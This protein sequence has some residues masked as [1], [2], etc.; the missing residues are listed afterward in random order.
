MKKIYTSSLVILMLTFFFLSTSGQNLIPL[1]NNRFDLGI[2]SSQWRTLYVNNIGASGNVNIGG[3]LGVTGMTNLNGLQVKGPATFTGIGSGFL[4]TNATG[5]L[6]A[7]PLTS[8]QIPTLPYLPLTGGALSGNLSGTGASFNNLS[9][10]SLQITG[11]TGSMITPG[12]ILTTDAYGNATWAPFPISTFSSGFWSTTGN[13]QTIDGVNFI[14][15]TDDVPLTIKVNGLL[16]GRIE[17]AYPGGNTFFG[18]GAGSL[19]TT[20]TNNTAFGVFALANH[21]TGGGNTAIGD[22]VLIRNTSGDYNTILG[23]AAFFTNETGSFLTGLG[24]G[25]DVNQ[26]GYT[27]ST[28]IGGSAIIDASNEIMLGNSEITTIKAAVTGITALS[29]GRFKKNI[30][31]NVPGLEFIKLLK[32]VTY[33]YN[34]K[35]LKTYGAPDKSNVQGSKL[36]I[37][38][39]PSKSED[40][41]IALKEKIFYTGLVAQDVETAAKKAGY[42]F[43][44]LYKPQNGKDTYGLNYTEFVV[45]L[46]KAT[47]QLANLNDSLQTQI[48]SLQNQL[49][50]IRAQLNSLSSS[51]NINKESIS[52]NSVILSSA[53]M[54]QNVPN[55]FNQSTII[56]YYIPH[57]SGNATVMVSD[58]NGRNI[59]TVPISAMGN[60]Q[61]SLQ[62]S[63]LVS[64]TY[65]YSLY[66]DGNLVDSKKMVLAK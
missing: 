10:Q 3:A 26:D 58:I 11:A 49:N 39:Q 45:P 14:G 29:D 6:T 13:A 43:S 52:A 66:I 59:K 19:N 5:A 25:T 40:A 21:N 44:G 4:S 53:H 47:Q 61:I 2:P 60:G 37:A 33:N 63:Q 41:A 20:G 65:I 18:Y 15:T 31:E 30:K 24:A 12:N 32:P 35:G 48:N 36:I 56:N 22:G 64:G 8:A 54:D 50:E 57:S 51:G 17:T 27:N 55:P 7:A 42:D 23:N 28:A 34:I 9:I 62:T 1:I 38:L 46:I 16:S